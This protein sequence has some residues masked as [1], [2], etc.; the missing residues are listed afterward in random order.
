LVNGA[1]RTARADRKIFADAVQAL[2]IPPALA[3]QTAA[4]LA[5]PATVGTRAKAWRHQAVKGIG[6]PPQTPTALVDGSDAAQPG[7]AETRAV[8][9]NTN[10]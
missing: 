1:I 2:E 3:L 4:D 7:G 10:A 8:L 5:W 6:T 9:R